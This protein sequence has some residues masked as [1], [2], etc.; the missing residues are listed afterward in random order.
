LLA[1]AECLSPGNARLLLEKPF[2]T[3]LASAHELDTFL[4]ALLPEES[5]YRIDHYL[6]KRMARAIAEG[7]VALP[8]L[9]SGEVERIDIIASE[10]EDVGKRADFYDQ[11]GALRDVLEN[12]LTAL[13]ATLLAAPKSGPEGRL[14][15]LQGLRIGHP[16]P[17]RV[18][19]EG[20]REAVG[21]PESITET[22]ASVGLASSDPRYASAVITLSTGKA[23]KEKRT[24]IRIEVRGGGRVTISFDKDFIERAAVGGAAL[25]EPLPTLAPFDGYAAAYQDAITGDRRFFV[26]REEALEAWRIVQPV[27][28]AWKGEAEME[29]YARGSAVE[30]LINN[31]SKL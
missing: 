6:E 10:S 3:D 25:R 16:A 22:F 31:S 30:D 24:E 9:S 5:T 2:G 21:K 18:Q 13:L 27:I 17:S 23:L 7:V 4:A 12:H 11:V 20:Y 29:A 26:G 8:E 19:Y 15:A 1:D 14:E 28:D